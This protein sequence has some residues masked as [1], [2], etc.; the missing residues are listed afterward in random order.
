MFLR[1][2]RY[3]ALSQISFLLL[4]CGES[5]PAE[6]PSATCGPSNAKVIRIWD[7]DTVDLEGDL[8]IRYLLVDA[9]EIAHGSD[10]TSECF[11]L[12]AKQLNTQLVLDKTVQ[13]TYD[14][15]CKDK[16]DRLLGFVSV[17]NRMVNRVLIERGYARV[18]FIPPNGKEHLEDFEQLEQSAKESNLGLWGGCP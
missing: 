2:T 17:D 16:Y 13:I 12:E 1:Y 7:G 4:G 10:E 11:A 18:L 3:L 9:P 14:T 8:R 15:E 5:P 6:A